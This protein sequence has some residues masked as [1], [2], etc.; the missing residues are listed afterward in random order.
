MLHVIDLTSFSYSTVVLPEDDVSL[1][2][3]GN[4]D[5]YRLAS[6]ANGNQRAGGVKTNP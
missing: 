2:V 5:C 1:W 3:F 6:V 4:A